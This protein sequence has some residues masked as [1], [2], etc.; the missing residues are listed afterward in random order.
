VATRRN[1]RSVARRLAIGFVVV[2]IAFAITIGVVFLDMRKAT[3][4]AELLRS[5]YVPLQLYVGE[6]M[7]AQS[8]LAAQLNHIT[9]AKNPADVREW[10]ETARR[11][12]PLTFT[13]V[14]AAIEQIPDRDPELRGFRDE[15]ARE[16]AS[17]EE[18]LRADAEGF[19]RLFQALALNESETV[20][21]TH[22]DLIKREAEAGQRLRAI[23]VRIEDRMERL[24]VAAKA[25]ETRSF[26]FLIGLSALTLVVGLIV[27]L[28]ARRVLAPLARV[29]DRA[30]AV[31][32]GDLRPRPNEI[33]DRSEIG[34]LSETFENMVSAIDRARRELVLAERLATIGKMA[35][36]VTHEIRNPLSSIGLNI[37]LLES[38]LADSSSTQEEKR[39][40]LAAIKAETNRLS[41]LSEQYLSIARRPVPNR[42]REDVGAVCGELCTFLKPELERAQIEIKLDVD[43][44]TPEV[45]VD[46]A[47]LRQALLN[48]IRNAREA[49]SKGGTINI[50]VGPAVG[51]GVDLIVEDDGP[52]IPEDVRAHIFDP[53]FTT[54]SRG[55]GLGLAV[56][57]EIIEAHRGTIACE[58]REKGTR[59]RVFLPDTDTDSPTRSEADST[60]EVET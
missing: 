5:A 24:M 20:T 28:Y 55:T 39:A 51:G 50:R 52:G 27:S 44:T 36:H 38:E 54:K 43:P 48:L 9:A 17:I 33:D 31:A 30:K 3:V 8:V 7:A 4:D 60:E 49:M 56:T 41:M 34:E 53:F 59:F 45:G 2:L 37:E 25:R 46:E 57:R 16:I 10:I 47:Q 18:L 40:L 14:R 13:N 11:T 29:T 35:A 42:E 12:R 26:E 21:K 1:K 22:S 19:G 58:A 23:K 15:L 6:A 32:E